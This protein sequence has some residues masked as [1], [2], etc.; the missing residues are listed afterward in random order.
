MDLV[1]DNPEFLQTGNKVL[2]LVLD[3][4]NFGLVKML[5]VVQHLSLGVRH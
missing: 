1:S 3:V 2:Q 4:S 5:V